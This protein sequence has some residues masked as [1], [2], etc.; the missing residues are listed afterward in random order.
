ME[1]GLGSAAW[2]WRHVQHEIAKGSRVCVYDRAGYFARST[3]AVGPRTAG[4][5]ADDLFALLGAA[6]IKPPYVFV[7][8]SYGGYIVRLFT[9][10]HPRSVAG[11]V[12]VD[13]SSEFQKNV[14]N[15]QPPGAQA[16]DVAA[17]EKLRRCASGTRSPDKNC[18]F[19]GQPRDLPADLAP[20]FEQAQ[21]AAYASTMLR[22]TE[23]MNTVS[24]T[25]LVTEKRS[26]GALPVVVLEQTSWPPGYKPSPEM[27]AFGRVALRAWHDLHLETLSGISS[28]F[29]LRPVEGASHR[30]EDDKPQA[31]IDSVNE[32]LAL[33]RQDGA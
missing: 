9:Y 18:V 23:A 13:P 8:A 2:T 30:I 21:D 11:M 12:L 26:L 16:A 3:P 28:R 20:W 25:E 5:E 32:V 17:L 4:A 10:R 22:E 27:Q 15:L 19:A 7:G 31:V 14:A 6:H 24:S 1:S 29:V 33:A